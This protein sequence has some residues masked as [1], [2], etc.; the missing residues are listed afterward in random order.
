MDLLN[1]KL[2]P[3][4]YTATLP[5][6]PSFTVESADFKDGDTMPNQHLAAG[7]NSSPHLKWYGFPEE[8]KSFLVTCFDPDAPTPSGYW[9]WLITDLP[10]DV[11][12]LE[13]GIGSS[14]LNLDGPAFHLR[15]DAGEWAYFGAAPPAG[16]H[17]HRYIF[18]VLALDVETLELEEDTS[19]ATAN[20]K[21]LFHTLARAT[22]TV[23]YQQ[24]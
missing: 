13:A 14:D 21:A 6:V 22:I 11:T 3:D 18:A 23:T 7:G 10:A 1:R 19:P 2:S 4:P 20:F 9:H 8:T 17:P 24:Q 5:A 15:N 16:D 12:E